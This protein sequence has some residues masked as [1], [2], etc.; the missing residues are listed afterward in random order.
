V[1]DSN[2]TAVATQQFGQKHSQQHLLT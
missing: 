2:L 1:C